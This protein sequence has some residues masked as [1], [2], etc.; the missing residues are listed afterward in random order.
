MVGTV[1]GT[2]HASWSLV[3]G[4]HVARGGTCVDDGDQA[5]STSVGCKLEDAAP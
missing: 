2:P 5:L 1:L 3:L 4:K